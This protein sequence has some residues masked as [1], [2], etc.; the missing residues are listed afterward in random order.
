[1]LRFKYHKLYVLISAICALLFTYF[2]GWRGPVLVG[3]FLMVWAVALVSLAP[4]HA[5]L[6][7]RYLEKA[8]TKHYLQTLGL[9]LRK[10]K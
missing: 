6:A 5:S 7:P 2:E 10:R 9:V 8:T 1:M 4:V 3:G